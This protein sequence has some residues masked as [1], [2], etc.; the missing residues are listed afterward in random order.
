MLA[1]LWKN[2]YVLDTQ[3]PL[4]NEYLVA[5]PPVARDIGRVQLYRFT[6][7]VTSVAALIST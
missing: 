4:F 7:S 3:E 5:G 1:S 2:Q 6:G